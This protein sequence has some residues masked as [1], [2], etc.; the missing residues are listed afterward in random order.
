MTDEEL[1]RK[2]L[3]FSKPLG[4]YRNPEGP[5]AVDRIEE[6]EAHIRVLLDNDPNDITSDNGYCV[7]DTWRH[8]ARHS[9]KIKVTNDHDG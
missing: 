9:L 3:M 1:K 8:E 5:Q 7:L 4:L 2:L 6:L